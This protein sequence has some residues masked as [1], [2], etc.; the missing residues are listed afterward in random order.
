MFQHSSNKKCFTIESLVGKEALSH[1]AGDEPIRPTALRFP[2]SLHPAVFG[3]GFQGSARQTLYSSAGHDMVLQEPGTHAQSPGGGLP[4]HPLQIPPQSFF[5]AQH[6]DAL[7]FYPWVLRGRYLGHRFTGDDSSP[8]NLLLH[9]P[10]SRKPKRIRTAFSPSQLLRL[11]RAFEKNH[12]VVGAERKQLA[13]GLCLTE[14]QVKVWF[15]NRRTKH[16]R[17]KL[18]EESPEAQQ[19]RKGSQH[20]NRWRAATQQP[21]GEDVD[22]I[23]DD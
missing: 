10:F 20:V 22:V 1:G 23:S 12:Y 18:E 5:S 15:Q 2:E 7:S 17:Q 11:E 13:S 6:R 3:S 16:K 9:G 14:T 21:G 8:E 4:L 19:K